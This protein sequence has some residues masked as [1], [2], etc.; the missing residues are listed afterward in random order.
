VRARLPDKLPLK[1]ASLGNPAREPTAPAAGRN[2]RAP[3]A[4]PS[5][6]RLLAVVAAVILIIIAVAIAT[7]GGEPVTPPATGAAALVPSDALAYIHFSTDTSRPEVRSALALAGRFP[8][9]SRLQGEV[10]AGLDLGPLLAGSD[11]ESDVS[12]W[13]GKEVAIALLDTGTSTGQSLVVVDVGNLHGAERFLAAR[14]TDGTATYEGTTI[15]GHPGAADTALVGHYLLIGHGSSIRAAIDVATRRAPA[16]SGDAAYRRATMAEPAG[17]AAD[18]YFSASGVTRILTPQVGLAGLAGALLYQP[19]LKGVAVALT[20]VPGGAQMYVHTVLDPRLAHSPAASFTPTLVSRVPSGAALFLD[21]N[22]LG[23]LL[24]RVLGTIGI[25]ARIP[26]LLKK[27]GA[28]LTAEG[29][30]V[31]QD[32]VKLFEHESAVVISTHAGA[33]VV[34]VITHTPDPNQTRTVFAQLQAPLARLFAP[35]GN[36]AVQAPVFNQATVGGIAVHQLVLSPGLQFDYAVSGNDLVLSTSLAGIAAVAHPTTSITSEPAYQRALGNRPA[37][38]TSLLFLDLNQLLSLGNE[39]GLISG[40]RIGALEP[41]LRQVHAIGLDSTSGEAEST[42]E[43]FLQ[44][45]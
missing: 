9:F 29:V 45:P 33:P 43:L 35:A 5:D 1:R 17:R 22:G 18:A 15:T 16:L 4:T 30:N 20:P 44:I 8:G 41:D 13:I 14:R 36:A 25:G 40:A 19:A 23:Q 21:T 3:G 42:A 27:L 6:R 10:I 2:D 39:T 11:F 31:H 12:P 26:D 32:I 28:A 7:S 37:R 38:V 34:T 24:P